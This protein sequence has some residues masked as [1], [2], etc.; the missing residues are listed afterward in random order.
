MR[1]KVWPVVRH[2]MD[3]KAYRRPPERLMADHKPD[4]AEWQ[5]AFVWLIGLQG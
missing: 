1:Q 4:A 5:E 3:G 2:D